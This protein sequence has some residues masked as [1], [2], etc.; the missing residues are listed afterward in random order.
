MMRTK[1]ETGCRL[2]KWQFG[3]GVFDILDG[4]VSVDFSVKV[5]FY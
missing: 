4:V 3:V 5:P 1:E 2:E